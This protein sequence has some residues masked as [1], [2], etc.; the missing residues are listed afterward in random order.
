[1]SSG[2]WTMLTLRGTPFMT[3][4]ICLLILSIVMYF[5]GI[6]LWDHPNNFSCQIFLWISLQVHLRRGS[7]ILVGRSN[8]SHSCLN[9]GISNFLVQRT[10]PIIGSHDFSIIWVT[11]LF[12]IQSTVVSYGTQY[13]TYRWFIQL[14]ENCVVQ[15]A[16]WNGEVSE[17]L[18][19]PESNLLYMWGFYGCI[20]LVFSFLEFKLVLERG[21]ST[22]KYLFIQY[23]RR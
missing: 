4:R 19:H 17:N 1:M 21:I 23:V 22:C 2:H 15:F 13:F 5:L 14:E 6:M 10:F 12:L 16:R 3:Q 9:F 18:I 7:Q 20:L 8:I 11:K